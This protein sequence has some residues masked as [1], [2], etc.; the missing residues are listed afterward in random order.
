VNVLKQAAML[1]VAGLLSSAAGA[2]QMQGASPQA[3][4]PGNRAQKT[5]TIQEAEALALENNPRITVGKLRALQAR[6][7]VREA[8]SALWPEAHLS[9]TAVDANPGSRIAA[10]ALTNPA[11]YSRA[12]AGATV[13]QLITDFGRTSN[14]VSSSQFQA[15]A[16]D[17]NAMAT[18]Q[19]VILAVDEAFYNTLETQ[20]LLKVAQQTVNARQTLVD[21]VQA[22]R[23]AKLRSDL[24]LSFGKVN[25]ARARLLVLESNNSYQASLSTLSAILGYPDRQDFKLIEPEPATSAPPESEPAPLIQKAMQQRPEILALQNELTSAEKFSKAEH[26]LW[27]PTVSAAGTVGQVPTRDDHVPSWW[28]AVGVNVNI[29]VFNGF[30]FNA[31]GKSADLETESKRKQLQE[32]QDSIARDVRNSW[33]DTQKAYARL[34]V[35]EQLREQANLALDL[36]QARYKLGLSSIVEYSQAE[37][38]KTDADL[39]GTDAIYQYRLSQIVLGYQMGERR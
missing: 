12:A 31:R 21:Q 18:Q 23:D 34:G 8:R 10:G 9:L 20:A 30:L 7:F 24:D 1:L 38:Q 35:T 6:E 19:D 28:G 33:L 17:Q 11:L 22:L 37:L 4:A 27:W 29:P 15:K 3:T 13:S 32:E 36:A 2:Q 5:L 26:D 14:L 25:L 39:Q 16:E